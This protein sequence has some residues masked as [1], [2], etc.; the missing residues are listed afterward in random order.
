MV[1]FEQHKKTAEKAP[2]EYRE[3]IAM[4]HTIYNTAS[5]EVI[6]RGVMPEPDSCEP[7]FLY[8]SLSDEDI[9]QTDAAFADSLKVTLNKE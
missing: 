6:K 8:A 3:W 7:F 4:D 1:P 5:F 2:T 9:A